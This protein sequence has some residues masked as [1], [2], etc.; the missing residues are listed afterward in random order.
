MAFNAKI[1]AAFVVLP[2]FYLVYLLGAKLS[3]GRRLL[4]LSL[5]SVAL[6]A[7]S[8][9][10]VLFVDLTPPEKRPYA[11]STSDN[12]MLS[13]ALGWNG[14]QRLLTRNNWRNAETA[15][16]AA[17]SQLQDTSQPQ[18]TVQRRNRRG[19]ETGTPGPF[20]LLK[21]ANA[22]QVAWMLPLVLVA[23]GFFV[24][25]RRW[26]FPLLFEDQ[27]DKG[28]IKPFRKTKWRLTGKGEMASKYHHERDAWNKQR[29][30]KG[31]GKN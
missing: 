17:A 20:R 9:L 27:A 24:R 10:W 26:R 3:L 11:G 6:F 4:D 8:L 30:E 5:A 31:L 25:D 14:F 18:D 21:P 7:V 2:A 15:S 29:K 23:I 13:L 19:N 12:S 1:F 22:A 28:F 16:P